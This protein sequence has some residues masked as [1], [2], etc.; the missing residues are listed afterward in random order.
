M[1]G[2]DVSPTPLLLEAFEGYL[3]LMASDSLL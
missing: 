2:G 3:T 1:V